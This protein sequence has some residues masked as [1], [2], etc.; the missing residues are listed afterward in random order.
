MGW[1]REDLQGGVEWLVKEG[2]LPKWDAEAKQVD[3]PHWYFTT[4]CVFQQ[5]GDLWKDWNAALKKALVENQRKDGD[6]AGSWDAAG[7][8]KA[9]L[10]RVG[11]TALAALC[12]ETYY[13]YLPLYRN[14]R[15][16]VAP[17]APVST[18][19]AAPAPIAAPKSETG[20]EAVDYSEYLRQLQEGGK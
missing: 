17:S 19:A 5:G 12:L 15:A 4:L 14:S 20:K 6:E 8:E 7:A 18:P 3:A 10:G 16:S 9:T 1:K 11:V 2:G 13:R